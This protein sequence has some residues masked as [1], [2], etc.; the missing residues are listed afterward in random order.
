MNHP[1]PMVPICSYGSFSYGSYGSSI[2]RLRCQFGSTLGPLIPIRCFLAQPPSRVTLDSREGILGTV[3]VGARQVNLPP[4]GT[5]DHLGLLLQLFDSLKLVV[6][7][8]WPQASQIGLV[9]AGGYQSWWLSQLVVS[10]ACVIAG[11]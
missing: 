9:Q 10:I 11:G 2:L 3:Q 8:N 7:I 1:T 5:I 6:V 4:T